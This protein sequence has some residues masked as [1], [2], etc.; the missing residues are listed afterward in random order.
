MRSLSGSNRDLET[1]ELSTS[2][3]QYLPPPSAFSS[4]L[5]YNGLFISGA[6]MLETGNVSLAERK[7]SWLLRVVLA[8]FLRAYCALSGTR[9]R[10]RHVASKFL[11]G[12]SGHV[13]DNGLRDGQ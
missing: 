8:P 7:I 3:L 6:F 10:Y 11:D 12:G 1:L 2:R 13:P 5:G 9:L 4:L